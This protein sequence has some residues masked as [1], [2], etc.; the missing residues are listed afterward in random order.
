MRAMDEV[1]QTDL[2]AMNEVEQT[3]LQFPD[4]RMPAGPTYTG[5]PACPNTLPEC[6][7]A[8]ARSLQ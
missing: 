3:N 1:E 6:C 4:R 7:C 8:G 5:A 2:R